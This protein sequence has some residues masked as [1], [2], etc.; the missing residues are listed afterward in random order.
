MGRFLC[1]GST[2][3]L[4]PGTEIVNDLSLGQRK[5]AAIMFTDMVGYTALGQRDESLSF[6]LI[7]E[8][9][10]LVRQVLPRHNGREIKTIGDAFLVVFASALE[11]ARCAYDIQVA[12]REFNASKPSDKRFHLRIGLHLGDVLESGGDV[13]GDAV[14]VASRIEPLADEDGVCLTRQVYDQVLNKTDLSLIF[15]GAKTLKNVMAPLEVYRM[16]MPWDSKNSARASTLDR[17]R[18]A[19]LPFANMSPNPDDEFF[20]DG[21]TEEL[22]SALSKIE[23]VEVISRTSVMLYKK[24]PKPIKEV[25]KELEAGTVIEGS[26]RKSGNKLRVTVQMIDASR[27]K[28]LWA[29]SYD[30]ELDDVFEIQSDISK[31]VSEALQTRM[32]KEGPGAEKPPASVESYTSYLRAVQ[33]VYQDSTES[34]KAA[35]DLL[36]RATSNDPG[37][38]KAYAGLSWAWARL[39]LGH[40]DWELAVDKAEVAA[41]RAIQLDPNLAEAHAALARVFSYRDRFD[42]ELVEAERAV[43][44]NPNLAEGF[45]I[46]GLYYATLGRLDEGYKHMSKAHELDPL[47]LAFYFPVVAQLSGREAEA[48]EV[49]ERW[50]TV[51]PRNPSVYAAL[52]G[53]YMAKG[54]LATAQRVQDAGI[55]VDP[56]DGGLLTNQGLIYAFTQRKAEAEKTLEA[57]DREEVEAAR[58]YGQVRVYAGLGRLDDAFG[59]LDRQ[60]E[61]HSWD[62]LILTLPLFE[63]MRKDPRFAVFCAKAGLPYRQT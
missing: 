18:V 50:K 31:R 35:V 1:T 5:L 16:E 25:A 4:S 51:Y 19:V 10:G 40:V 7:E 61:I 12:A 43:N 57:I 15:L 26:V 53:F 9:R 45:S 13:S 20:S 21:M 22:I 17:R 36:E 32:L 23:Q 60:A 58:L 8:Q 30:R 37:F 62:A 44:I 27:D 47:S 54:D 42:E 46:L 6:A 55:E 14:N 34:L 48:L 63:A 39:A 52:S 11:A 49:L 24:A 41:R 38:A 2:T 28:H 3:D 29:D 59:A 33:L 56:T